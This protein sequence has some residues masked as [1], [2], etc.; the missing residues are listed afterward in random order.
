MDADDIAFPE[1]FE[2]QLQFFENNPSYDLC[3]TSVIMID[4][5][6]KEI[7]KWMVSNDWKAVR[8]KIL[9]KNQIIHPTVMF[10]RSFISRV[11]FYKDWQ[12]TFSKDSFP[13]D[14]ELWVR[15]LSKG[16]RIGNIHKPLLFYRINPKGITWGITRRA[17]LKHTLRIQWQAIT[18]YDF[19]AWQVIYLG[20]RLFYLLMNYMGL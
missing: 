8:R 13:E 17:L 1:R 16:I 4:G 7:G 14:L 18:E 6:G 5:D 15:A 20:K 3:G 19:P 10:R 12:R 9:W 2:R 11:G